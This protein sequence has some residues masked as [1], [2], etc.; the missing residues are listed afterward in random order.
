MILKVQIHTFCIWNYPNEFVDILKQL[1][2]FVIFNQWQTVS[3]SKTHFCESFKQHQEYNESVLDTSHAGNMFFEKI[4]CTHLLKMFRVLAAAFVVSRNPKSSPKYW[5]N[6]N[7]CCKTD[8]ALSP[9]KMHHYGLNPEFSDL[10]EFFKLTFAQK[11]KDVE[12]IPNQRKA[13]CPFQCLTPAQQ[14]VWKDYFNSWLIKKRQLHS[15]S[16]VFT[17]LFFRK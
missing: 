8:I 9:Q 5:G 6:S 4:C 11:C 13:W 2:L 12:Q 1:I 14:L 16:V 7:M 15:I 17:T 10:Y 3:Q